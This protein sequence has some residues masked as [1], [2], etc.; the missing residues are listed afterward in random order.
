MYGTLSLAGKFRGFKLH[1]L[2]RLSQWSDVN[3]I[4]YQFTSYSKLYNTSPQ[5]VLDT[6]FCN[7]K[8][9]KRYQIICKVNS[10]R[11]RVPRGILGPVL[12][13]QA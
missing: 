5:L 10:S 12:L 2:S 3:N 9:R 8:S 6:I 4:D 11:K 1:E 13:L 7:H